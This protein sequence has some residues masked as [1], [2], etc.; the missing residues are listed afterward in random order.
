MIL[1]YEWRFSRRR[2]VQI[3]EI[4][5]RSCSPLQLN[6]KEINFDAHGQSRE[7]QQLKTM[8]SFRQTIE[9]Q[10]VQFETFRVQLQQ[11]FSDIDSTLSKIQTIPKQTLPGI[12]LQRS[13]GST[14]IPSRRPSE[15]IS[16]EQP[17]TMQQ[18]IPTLVAPNNQNEVLGE[19]TRLRELL[20]ETFVG[21]GD[22]P[23]TAVRVSVGSGSSSSTPHRSMAIVPNRQQ[24]QVE[25]HPPFPGHVDSHT[26]NY[27]PELSERVTDLQL[28]VNRLHQDV[29]AIRQV[30]ERM[31]PLSTS[32]ILGRTA[33]RK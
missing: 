13:Q 32:L 20:E 14:P 5:H 9:K 26:S 1:G 18:S 11:K 27:P 19:L 23:V 33:G 2:R 31:S 10:N 29:S 4:I 28:A 24:L 6:W 25:H 3:Q 21:Q 17:S 16:V 8:N 22:R 30:I 7:E 15:H 12:V